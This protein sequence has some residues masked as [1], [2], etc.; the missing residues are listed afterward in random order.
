MRSICGLMD[1]ASAQISFAVS[2]DMEGVS[3]ADL[4]YFG[5]LLFSRGV[6]GARYVSPGVVTLRG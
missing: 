5:S 4:T 6:S 1:C 2:L 3:G